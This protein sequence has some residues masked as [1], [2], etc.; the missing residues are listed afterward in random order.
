[1]VGWH[2]PAPLF[3]THWIEVSLL[4]VSKATYVE[5]REALF[6]RNRI[7]AVV[8]H[9]PVHDGVGLM[10]AAPDTLPLIAEVRH[11]D[12]V[13]A[14][15]GWTTDHDESQIIYL[16]PYS[17]FGAAFQIRA[18][19]RRVKTLVVH[20]HIEWQR[21][22]TAATDIREGK[23]TACGLHGIRSV[24]F[25]SVGRLE[26]VAT[27]GFRMVFV[28]DTVVSLWQWLCDH[29]PAL[30]ADLK[31]R[32]DLGSEKA[33]AVYRVET[34][35]VD[36]SILEAYIRPSTLHNIPTFMIVDF[37]AWM[38]CN[39]PE[40]AKCDVDSFEFWTHLLVMVDDPD[41]DQ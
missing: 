39:W 14:F 24:E 3:R 7:R 9:D 31:T 13:A 40:Y 25:T 38:I 15:E 12:I 4:V 36:N 5:A 41:G 10:I 34:E 28:N 20:V 33:E 21:F 22:L 6:T 27:D 35:S 1:M 17:F 32:P 19:N 16:S 18:Q 23:L 30:L 8:S 2:P 11:L 37:W 29:A 26:I